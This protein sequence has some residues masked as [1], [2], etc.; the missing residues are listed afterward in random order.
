LKSKYLS[1]LPSAFT[2]AV[3]PCEV[4]N[5]RAEL[6]DSLISALRPKAGNRA[7]TAGEMTALRKSRRPG[8]ANDGLLQWFR[9]NMVNLI[10]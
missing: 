9:A 3:F 7:P 2:I 5:R 10:G 1:P 6:F 4:K 8:V